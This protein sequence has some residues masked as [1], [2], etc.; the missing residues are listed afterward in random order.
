MTGN[1]TCLEGTKG[2]KGIERFGWLG[3]VLTRLVGLVLLNGVWGAAG[4]V[5][6]AVAEAVGRVAELQALGPG[7][8]G[9][10]VAD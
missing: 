9:V 3:F 6:G 10:P 5:A 7:L 2:G 8:P 1:H 4:V